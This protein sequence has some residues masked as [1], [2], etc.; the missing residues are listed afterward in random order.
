[1]SAAG[2]LE[3]HPQGTEVTALAQGCLHS[4]GN[5]TAHTRLWALGDTSCLRVAEQSLAD[6]FREQL[7]VG[8]DENPA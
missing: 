5:H 4:V 7:W 8:E 6:G 2:Y 1:M 3:P